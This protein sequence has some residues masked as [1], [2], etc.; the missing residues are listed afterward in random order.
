M[1]APYGALQEVKL[2]LDSNCYISYLNRRDERQFEIMSKLMEAVSRTEHEVVLTGHNMTEIAYVLQSI[3]NMESRRVHEILAAF[4][5]NPGI[6]FSAGHFPARLLEFWPGQIKDYGDAVIASAA[7]VLGTRVFT[8]DQGFSRALRR[9][10][11]E[12]N[13]SM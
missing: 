5:N 9:L 1:E 13:M 6:E 8:F 11:L 3:Y 7:S 4:I 12:A 2:I 10:D